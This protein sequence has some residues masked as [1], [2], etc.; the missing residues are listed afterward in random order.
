MG[1][2]REGDDDV[3]AWTLAVFLLGVLAG[4]LVWVPYTLRESQRRY[5]ERL[6]LARRYWEKP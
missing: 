1:R 4:G 3:I 5:E 6:K 2:A